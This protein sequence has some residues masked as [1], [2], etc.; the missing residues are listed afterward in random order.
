MSWIEDWIEEQLVRL[1]G[2]Q[3][4]RFRSARRAPP[5]VGR[6]QAPV[7]FHF[8]AG[9]QPVPQAGVGAC[10]WVL[11]TSSVAQLEN[12]RVSTR[13]TCGQQFTRT[14]EDDIEMENG[15]APYFWTAVAF[16]RHA[17]L[18]N[19]LVIAQVM[20]EESPLLIVVNP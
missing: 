12:L 4:L 1:T 13:C 10:A 7:Q 17:D 6:A 9:G 16:R 2:W 11:W 15:K 19:R 3:P 18:E 20:A 5:G 8:E 14:F